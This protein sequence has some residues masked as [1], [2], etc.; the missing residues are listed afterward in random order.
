MFNSIINGGIT[1]ENFAAC[2]GVAFVLGLI[3]AL[4]HMKTTHSNRN[5]IMTL[6]ILPVLV[7]TVILM[8]NGNLGTGVAVMGAFSLVR[9]RS[10]PGNS[11]AILSVFFAMAIGLAVGTGYIAFA[12]VFT[13]AV[14]IITFILHLINFGAGSLQEKKLTLLVPEDLDYTSA[15]DRT[16]DKYLNG[17]TLEKAKTTNLGSLF[18]LTYRINLKKG[19]NEKEFIDHLRTKNGNL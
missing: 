15:F 3:V 17:Y 9:F 8:V 5:F 4:T 7:T 18:E 11:R 2:L 19:I 13:V 1:I 6:S 10:I 16:F 12:A 14:A